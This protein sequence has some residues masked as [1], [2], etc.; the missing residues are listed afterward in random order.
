M[1]SQEQRS[2]LHRI[3]G[4]RA[5]VAGRPRGHAVLQLAFA[6]LTTAYIG[7]LVFTGSTEGGANAFGGT[8]MP[9]VL[10]PMI[11][12]SAL[13]SGA[14]ER[15]GE[16]LRATWVDGIA[17]GS[18]VLMI[19]GV[20]AWGIIAGGY[21]WWIAVIVSGVTLILFGMR[22]LRVLLRTRGARATGTDDRGPLS[23][24]VRLTTAFLGVFFGLICALL[25]VPALAWTVTMLGLI[26]VLIGLAARG[27]PWSFLNTGY[28]WRLAQW[29]AFGIA[30]SV[31]FLLA[32]LL[33]AT[34]AVTPASAAVA[35]GIVIACLVVSAV[36]PG[37][38]R[39]AS[40]A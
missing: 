23:L 25:F 1:E 27:E 31:M 13:M 9:L 4:I 28:E 35:G 33:L 24:P 36:L 34:D 10:V 7:V 12:S 26:I 29:T 18:L 15:F 22:P 21:P 17:A 2:S 37:S 14:N 16:R 3:E 6:L 11:V 38:S 39:G 8:T 40:A 19:L 30:A 32:V 20:L 5:S